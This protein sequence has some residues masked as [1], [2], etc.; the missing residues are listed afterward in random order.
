MP[1]WLRPASSATV[2]AAPFTDVVAAMGPHNRRRLTRAA[3]VVGGIATILTLTL[4]SS[5]GGFPFVHSSGHSD[6]GASKPHIYQIGDLIPQHAGLPYGMTKQQMI[7]RIGQPEKIAGQCFQYPENLRTWNGWTINAVRMCF[8]AGQYQTWFEELNGIWRRDG[9][10][11]H[12]IAPP[13]SISPP[14][15]DQTIPDWSKS[16]HE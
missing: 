7:R 14:L 5:G 4:W 12:K 8:Y 16:P 6:S 15:L 11:S 1:S 13:T 3:A 2:P 9:L 10:L